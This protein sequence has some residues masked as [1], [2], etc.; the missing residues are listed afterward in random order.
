MNGGAGVDADA[1]DV[2]AGMSQILN[3]AGGDGIAGQ[4]N[5]R[6]LVRLTL[7]EW[8]AGTH[9]IYDVRTIADDFR[10][11]RCRPRN[12]ALSPVDARRQ[13][14]APRRAR[15]AEARRTAPGN[16]GCRSAHS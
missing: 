3:E 7:E 2:A 11:Q 13:D 1:C 12:V 9:D 6:D 16:S 15:G 8:S 10:C 4:G 14:F 5:D